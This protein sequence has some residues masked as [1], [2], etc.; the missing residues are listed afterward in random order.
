MHTTYSIDNE[1]KN[2]YLHQFKKAQN[3][4]LN[5][6]NTDIN[7]V[8]IP[9]ADTLLLPKRWIDWKNDILSWNFWIDPHHYEDFPFDTTIMTNFSSLSAT[10]LENKKDNFQFFGELVIKLWSNISNKQKSDLLDFII[11][12]K[13]TDEIKQELLDT[14][15]SEN[16]NY[17]DFIYMLFD[18][19]VW[20]SLSV[21]SNKDI[22]SNTSRIWIAKYKEQLIK[23]SQVNI[24][25]DML[26]P[27][28]TS[29]RPEGY[30]DIKKYI[31]Y[32][33][34]LKSYTRS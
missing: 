33:W 26:I 19:Y 2:N 10:L 9:S 20:D 18:V 13:L 25:L 4:L 31:E 23:T 29:L 15:S 27:L 3:Q 32:W 11:L 21:W 14:I 34:D 28:N 24:T 1:D 16:S 30:A 7:A 17:K 6:W 12:T 5:L 8:E 22:A